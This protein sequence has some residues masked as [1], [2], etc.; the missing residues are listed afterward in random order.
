MKFVNDTVLTRMSNNTDS[1][2]REFRSILLTMK[3]DQVEDSIFFLWQQ[4]VS[5][6]VDIKMTIST[7]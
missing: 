3:A 4:V 7:Q 6:Y 2:S 5:Q 1:Q